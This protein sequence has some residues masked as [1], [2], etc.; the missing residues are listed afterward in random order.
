[1]TSARVSLRRAEAALHHRR[2]SS[3]LRR[4]IVVQTEEFPV[5]SR[6]RIRGCLE[7]G[8]TVRYGGA[9]ATKYSLLRRSRHFWQSV[10]R[11][12]TSGRSFRAAAKPQ[13]GFTTP[14]RARPSRG[15]TYPGSVRSRFIIRETTSARK[16]VVQH[17]GAAVILGNARDTACPIKTW[18]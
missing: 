3:I 12:R 10:E 2:I 14:A 5:A 16:D 6:V 4:M 17:F 15:R 7:A 8:I 9:A 1:M 13:I 18:P 11:K